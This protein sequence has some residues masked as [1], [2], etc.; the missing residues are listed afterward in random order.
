MRF[1]LHLSCTQ[2]VCHG[3]QLNI[4]VIS[5]EIAYCRDSVRKIASSNINSTKSKD[6]P[7]ARISRKKTKKHSFSSAH[8]IQ[9]HNGF[10]SVA[11]L[12]VRQTLE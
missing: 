12:T 2:L 11:G 7:T 4:G 9:G 8:S 6:T 5:G 3:L 1:D 10:Q